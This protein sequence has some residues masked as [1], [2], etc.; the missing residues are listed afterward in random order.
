[1][2]IKGVNTETVRR[3]GGA[4]KPDTMIEIGAVSVC[5]GPMSPPRRGAVGLTGLR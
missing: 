4:N 1:M 2:R 3:A 5:Q